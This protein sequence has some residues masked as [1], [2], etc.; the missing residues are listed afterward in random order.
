MGVKLFSHQSVNYRKVAPNYTS[1]ARLLHKYEYGR[2]LYPAHSLIQIEV[3]VIIEFIILPWFQLTTNKLFLVKNV[4]FFHMNGSIFVEC[5]RF[6][7]RKRHDL[8]Q[9]Q[10]QTS[11]TSNKDVSLASENSRNCD[12][13]VKIRRAYSQKEQSL[14]DFYS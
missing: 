2:A 9:P 7:I 8:G 12:K 13:A 10:V 4:R 5:Y 3:E 11:I 6:M 14:L 1:C